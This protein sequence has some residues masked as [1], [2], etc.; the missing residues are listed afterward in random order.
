MDHDMTQNHALD[1]KVEKVHSIFSKKTGPIEIKISEKKHNI[2]SLFGFLTI[3]AFKIPTKLII[4]LNIS[5]L[6]MLSKNSV[7]STHSATIEI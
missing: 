7:S 6:K 4:G 3:L 2:I 5:I 1:Q